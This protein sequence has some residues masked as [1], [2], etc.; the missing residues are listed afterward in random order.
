MSRKKKFKSG[1]LYEENSKDHPVID[2]LRNVF[3]IHFGDHLA[4]LPIVPWLCVF[5]GI[6]LL[7]WNEEHRRLQSVGWT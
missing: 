4:A 7:F 1:V 6:F 5:W 2:S 3:S